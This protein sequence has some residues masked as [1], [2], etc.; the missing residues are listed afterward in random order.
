MCWISLRFLIYSLVHWCRKENQFFKRYEVLVNTRSKAQVNFYWR[1][2]VEVFYWKPGVGGGGTP[3]NFCW[4]CAAC[5]SK[6]RPNLGDEFPHRFCDPLTPV[7]AVLY[8]R[9]LAAGLHNKIISQGVGGHRVYV[10]I[11]HPP[12]FRPKNAISH[13]HFQTWPQKSIP[14][15]RPDLVRD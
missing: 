3:W 6:S 12:N 2:K 5:I 8:Y 15:F 7:T 11:C 14:V 1:Y 13:T 10:G 9:W 4:G